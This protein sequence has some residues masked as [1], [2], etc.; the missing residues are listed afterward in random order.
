MAS[1]GVVEIQM[2][3]EVTAANYDKTFGINV[4]GLLNASQKAL[5]LMKNG[6]SIILV[7]SI[8]AFMGFP[9]Y[10]TYSATKAAIRSFARTW[11]AELKDRGVRVNVLSPGPIDT[12]II[13]SQAAT[14][15]GAEQ[16][17]AHFVSLIPA[18]RM[19][20]P[21]ELANAALFLASD[22]SSFIYGAEIVVDGGMGAV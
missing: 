1:A 14:K 11:T 22:E 2:F 13:D 5:P 4:R 6:G 12:P 19:G 17:R 8:L 9:G 3:G 15:E 21:E 7:S 20:R 10:T 18:G 16:L